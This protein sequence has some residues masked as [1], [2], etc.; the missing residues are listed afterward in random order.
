MKIRSIALLAISVP[1]CLQAIS[2][3]DPRLAIYYSFDAPPGAA[4]VAAM[5]SEVDRIL[6][7]AGVRSAWRA[8]ETRRNGEDFPG[9][10]FL[11]FRGVCSVDHPVS[12]NSRGDISGESLGQTDIEDGHVLPFGS[13]DCDRLRSFVAPGLKGLGEEKKNASLGRAMARVSAHEIYHML[14]ASEGHA[15]RGIARGSVSRADL[16]APT[17]AFGEAETRWLR[18]WAAV[19]SGRSDV[20]TVGLGFSRP[21]DAI[22]HSDTGASAGR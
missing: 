6:A 18:A 17:F 16:M 10:V 11:R 2:A 9:V 5:Q 20:V 3:S 22:R 19:P 12:G 14:T 1:A 15:R 13:V 7:E 21:E 8:L 4:L